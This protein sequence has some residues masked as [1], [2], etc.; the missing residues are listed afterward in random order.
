MQPARYFAVLILVLYFLCFPAE[1]RKKLSAD[2]PFKPRVSK[3]SEREFPVTTRIKFKKSKE[4]TAKNYHEFTQESG[5]LSGVVLD[6]KEPRL[7][8]LP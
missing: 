5:M 2:F 1:A 6:E 4:I 8:L 7:V 3:L